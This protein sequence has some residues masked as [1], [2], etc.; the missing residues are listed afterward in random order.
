MTR[1]QAPPGK[2]NG[3]P[4]KEAPAPYSDTTTA[5]PKPEVASSKAR[6]ADA[7]PVQLRRRRAWSW[8][9]EPLGCGRRDPIDPNRQCTNDSPSDYGLSPGELRR[10]ANQLHAQGWPVGEVVTVLDVAPVTP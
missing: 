9:C 7:L 10:H 6:G 1:Q 2:R 8:R 3:R 4:D 5:R